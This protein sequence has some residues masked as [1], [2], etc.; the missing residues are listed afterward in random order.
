MLI[1]NQAKRK[2]RD[3]AAEF[4]GRLPKARCSIFM[5]PAEHS[6]GLQTSPGL[7]IMGDLTEATA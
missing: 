5:G 7:D 1:G 4:Q 2:F 6:A 3:Q